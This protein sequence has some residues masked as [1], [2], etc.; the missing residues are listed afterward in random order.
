MSRR[1][2]SYSAYLA[3]KM[4]SLEFAQGMIM[5]AV[6]DGESIDNA[7]RM[8]VESAGVKEFSQRSG[9]AIQHLSAFV[10]GEK[11]FGQKRLERCLAVFELRLSVAKKRKV[12]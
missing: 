3:E 2:P 10:R 4:R 11:K 5:V 8:A 9:I 7:V 12:A 6:D 1:R